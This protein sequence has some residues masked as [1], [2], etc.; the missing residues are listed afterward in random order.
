MNKFGGNNF[1]N[2]KGANRTQVTPQIALTP[3]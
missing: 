2:E 1:E 3:P